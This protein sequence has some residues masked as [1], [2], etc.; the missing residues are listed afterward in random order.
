[1]ANLFGV[2]IVQM[3]VVPWDAEK[4]ME[5]MEQRLSYIRRAFPWVNLVCFPELCPTGTAPL[6][7]LPPGCAWD[8]TAE[9]IPKNIKGKRSGSGPLTER[10]AAMARRHQV[11]LQP[12]S[13]Y[14]RDGD[15]LYN[16]ALVFSPQGELVA[17]YRKMFPWRPWETLAGGREF[18]VFDIPDVGRFGL[19]ICYD[20]WFPEVIRTLT[21]M[22][23]EVIIHPSLTGTVDR[24]AELIIEQAHA[25]LN[26]C[27]MVNANTAPTTGGGK[28]IIVDPNGR[29]L[30]QAGAHEEIMTEI[31]DLDLVRRVRELGTVG[32]NQHLKQLRDFEGEFP[33]Y[34]QGIRQ[35]EMFQNL[36]PLRLPR[37]L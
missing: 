5:R 1:M 13:I 34:T 24:S 19:C 36:G 28:S 33:A 32:L 31:I 12:G 2:A 9:A 37:E 10:L 17:R 35:G 6:D 7:P 18:C 30:Q 15:A 11:W 20:G 21:W 22:G 14:E 8:A 26:Q 4:T 23:A 16:T 27:Y 3:Q 25:I 29:V